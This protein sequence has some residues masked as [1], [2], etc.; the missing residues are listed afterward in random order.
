[1][2]EGNETETKVKDLL[3]KAEEGASTELD[4]RAW[5]G[6]PSFDDAAAPTAAPELTATEKLLAKRAEILAHV[7]PWMVELLERHETIAR[8]HRVPQPPKRPWDGDGRMTMFDEQAAHAAPTEE[9]W[10]EVDIPNDVRDALRESAPQA[11]L[12][13]LHRPETEFSIQMQPPWDDEHEPPPLDPMEP[14]R[15]TVRTDYRVGLTITPAPVAMAA[16]IADLRGLL[17]RPWAEGKRERA[18]ARE[19]ELLGKEAERT[20]VEQEPEGPR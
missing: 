8:R 10:R 19:A 4:L 11:M 2:A 17:A 18:R 3:R 14:I 20:L 9:D 7:A 1:M 13:D 5:F 16:A 6:L 12:R 15:T